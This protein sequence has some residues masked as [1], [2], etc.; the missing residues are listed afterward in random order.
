MI[1]LQFKISA[2]I[3]LQGVK[4]RQAQTFDS[5]EVVVD[6]FQAALGLDGLSCFKAMSV[7]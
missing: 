6:K 5:L 1:F 4:I 2:N 3:Y 7:N